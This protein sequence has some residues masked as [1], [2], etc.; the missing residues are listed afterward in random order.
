MNDIESMIVL[1]VLFVL[2]LIGV[3][4]LTMWGEGRF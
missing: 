3:E 1:A 2:V 4:V